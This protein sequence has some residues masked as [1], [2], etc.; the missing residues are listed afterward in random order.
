[1]KLSK[2][3]TD[4]LKNFSAINMS[5][6]VRTGNTLKTISPTKT[7][8]AIANITETMPRE[9]ALYDLNQFLGVNSLFEDPELTFSDNHVEIRST[10]G[11][12]ACIKY[13]AKEAIVYAPDKDIT[14][15]DK[16]IAFTLDE[17]ALNSAL[18][19]ASILSLPEICIIGRNGKAYLTVTDSKN[20][21]SNT[22]EMTVGE[23][24]TDYRMI[25]RLDNLKLLP[26]SYN[27]IISSKGIC[28]F[29]STT[30]DV[31]YYIATE[32]NKQ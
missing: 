22:W 3:T 30:N 28:K 20:T 5:L 31:I 7:V 11:A 23:S 25:F 32:T 6:L 19:A 13:A 27:V 9:F 29:T 26:R 12:V 4:I 14:L 15:P 16:N 24:T 8:M 18:R 10:S 2:S 17:N 21:G 1:M